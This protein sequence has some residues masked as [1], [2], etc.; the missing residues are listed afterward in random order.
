VKAQ[1]FSDAAL[2]V[3]GHGATQ[4]AESAGPVFQHAA[5]LRRRGCCAQVREGFWKQEPQVTEVLSRLTEPRVFLAPLFISEGYFG[6]EI[7]PQALGFG[8]AEHGTGARIQ[9]R[10]RQILA[11]CRPVG[12]HPSMT[13]VLLAR[14]RGI[15]QRFPF[16]RAPKS[17][18][19]TLCIAGHGTEQNENSRVAIEHHV[20]ILRSKGLYA[21]VVALYLE[22]EPGI[23]ACYRLAPTRNVVVV[24]F[25]ISDGL[26]V[27]EDIP[28]LLGEPKRLVQERLRSAQPTWHNPTERH[29]KLVW[30]AGS[31]GTEPLLADVL[32]ERV[33]EA[34]G[35][36][37]AVA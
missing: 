31:V 10:G 15:V 6:G 23:G 37:G 9:A 5:E 36:V 16:P 22:E 19:T 1:E 25:F 34:A 18:D 7:I 14:A 12:T 17:E 4:N 24:P 26:H 20:E 33:R 27:R 35:W 29:G 28:V 11:Y 3:L 32:L 30:Y 21:E 13:Q 8:K 2:V